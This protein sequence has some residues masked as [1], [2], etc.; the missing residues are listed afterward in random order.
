MPGVAKAMTAFLSGEMRDTVELVSPLPHFPI[1]SR[2]PLTPASSILATALAS[3]SQASEVPLLLTNG[4]AKHDNP[5]EH[6]V[7]ANVEPVH[8]AKEPSTQA[9]SPAF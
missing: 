3:V 9:S 1:V 8:W 4:S 7:R 2:A 5:C 6:G